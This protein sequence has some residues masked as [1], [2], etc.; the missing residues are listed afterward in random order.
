MQKRPANTGALLELYRDHADEAII[1]RLE[2][3][4]LEIPAGNEAAEFSGALN[5]LFAQSIDERR[6][7]LLKKL[8]ST[9]LTPQEKE[10]LQKL[11]KA[12]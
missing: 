9:V 12:K 5:K 1:K 4:E 10:E 3:L 6:R 11:L 2:A 7:W 8:E